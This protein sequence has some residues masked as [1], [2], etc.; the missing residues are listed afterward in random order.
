MTLLLSTFIIITSILLI[1]IVLIQN[2]K[3]GGLSSTL[4]GGG[5]EIFGGVKKTTDFL[6]R[7]TWTLAIVLVVLVLATNAIFTPRQGVSESADLEIIEEVGSAP[8]TPQVPAIPQGE[9]A[10]EKSLPQS[11]DDE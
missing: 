2:P 8:A 11:I 3:G 1:V 10:I 5:T 9:E 4:G 7:G 6:D